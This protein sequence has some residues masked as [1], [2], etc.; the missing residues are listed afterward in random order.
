[1]ATAYNPQTKKTELISEE[2]KHK[3]YVQCPKEQSTHLG[4]DGV[5]V[6]EMVLEKVSQRDAKWSEW[7]GLGRKTYEL[8]LDPERKWLQGVYHL[9]QDKVLE[10]SFHDVWNVC[11]LDIETKSYDNKGFAKPPNC[12]FEINLCSLTYQAKKVVYALA[13][14]NECYSNFE[15]AKSKGYEVK[16]IRCEDERE[17]LLTAFK[18]IRDNETDIITGWNTEFFDIP[19]IFKRLEEVCPELCSPNEYTNA[20]GKKFTSGMK[21][22][23]RLSKF[24]DKP[25][26]SQSLFHYAT[27]G[28]MF[29]DYQKLYK[30]F[31][32][33]M[34]TSYS[35]ENICSVELD[36]FNKLT[37][38]TKSF[39]KFWQEH[40]DTFVDYNIIDSICIP[41]LDQ[42]L[43]LFETAWE[44]AT[45]ALIPLDQVV[46]SVR[47][48]SG[49]LADMVHE[50][51]RVC[52]DHLATGR[53]KDDE[54]EDEI[55]GGY[56]FAL[57]GF[58]KWFI[59]FDF[60][61]LYP[62]IMMLFN[63][64]PE[65]LVT[66]ITKEEA[67]E[68]N[69]IISPYE[70]VYYTREQGLIPRACKKFFDGRKFWKEKKKEYEKVGDWLS[71]KRADRKQLIKKTLINSMYG[72]FGNEWFP[73]FDARNANSVTAGGRSAIIHTGNEIEK[74]F[75]RLTSESLTKLVPDYDW[76]GW[77]SPKPVGEPM[78]I[79]TDTD[80][81][82]ISVARLWEKCN[83]GKL[84]DL[85]AFLKFGQMVEKPIFGKFFKASLAN[86]GRQFNVESNLNFKREK[87]G[88]A[89]LVFGKKKYLGLALDNEGAEYRDKETKEL[90]PKFFTTGVEIKRTDTSDFVR[91]FAEDVVLDI[92]N[93]GDYDTIT[94]MLKK[95]RVEFF[96][97]PPQRIARKCYVKNL[98]DTKR[99]I[100]SGHGQLSFE[101]TMASH[102]RACLSHNYINEVEML[103]FE[104]ITS[105][106]LEKMNHL[107]VHESNEYGIKNVGFI[108]E[109]DFK[110]HLQVDY[111][112]QFERTFEK[113]CE[114]L[115]NV[116]GWSLPDLRISQSRSR[117][118]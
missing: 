89:V 11:S 46:S 117:F 17:L 8:R 100:V 34:R 71:A 99:P 27:D 48:V 91:E 19:Y 4:Y 70:G 59:S 35:L 82:Y 56:V 87:I 40:W 20:D 51:G 26:K 18:I 112:K 79:L 25:V 9:A 88:H 5:P 23:V 75:E 111:E 62:F 29:I 45:E 37:K 116:L 14:E 105:T 41:E 86:W 52:P 50:Q 113:F 31:T 102:F 55:K 68:R 73:Y 90:K 30:K 16:Y 24:F 22:D 7:N 39:Q 3:Y 60:E 33:E 44:L 54:E 21:Y 77:D 84:N 47:V 49:V 96:K 15:V 95:A 78:V 93:G 114:R 32:Y 76:S 103:G 92:L 38:P 85:E 94:T 101:K 109:F 65:T 110:G 83:N 108:G 12:F 66:D 97:S 67:I 98:D 107:Y 74:G 28:I 10:Y 81:T 80:S 36:G 104:P 106:S 13:L 61:S 64:S 69:L 57:M 1:M 53:E 58:F 118:K 63:I 115:Y 72:V 42:E 2:Y 43:G 6:R